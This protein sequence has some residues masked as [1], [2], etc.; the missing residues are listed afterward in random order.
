WKDAV[1]AL[2]YLEST[3]GYETSNWCLSKYDRPRVLEAWLK[4]KRKV[5]CPGPIKEMTVDDME[6][7]TVVWWSSI[8]PKWRTLPWEGPEIKDEQWAEINGLYLVLAC[9]RWWLIL[10]QE[11]ELD[12]DMVSWNWKKVLSDIVWVI[13]TMAGR[14]PNEEPVSKKPHTG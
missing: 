2:V 3:Y 12:S 9:M 5:L 1:E 10:E 11:E 14:E 7:D 4:S 13:K 8:Q 6:S